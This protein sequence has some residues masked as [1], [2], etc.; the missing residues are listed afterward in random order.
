MRI[1]LSVATLTYFDSYEYVKKS[2][3]LGVSE[4]VAVYQAKP[5]EQII[6]NVI[7]EIKAEIH[8]KE[9]DLNTETTKVYFNISLS[10]PD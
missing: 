3:E 10:D 4:D 1:N 2:K 9:L 5:L 6:A 8:S 7:T